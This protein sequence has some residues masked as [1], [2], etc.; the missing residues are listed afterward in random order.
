MSQAIFWTDEE[1]AFKG[2]LMYQSQIRSIVDT[3][4]NFGKMLVIDVETGEYGIDI[5]GVT[6][7]IKLKGKRPTA[8][9]FM[10]KIGFDV[11]V[12]FGK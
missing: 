5:S 1:V 4:D 9:L 7:A 2:D 12:D 3:P 10:I 6:S 8:R 11:A